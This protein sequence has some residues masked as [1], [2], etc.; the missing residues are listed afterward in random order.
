M[1]FSV[2]GAAGWLD[3]SVSAL[4]AAIK[5]GEVAAI[6]CT[7]RDDK[8]LIFITDEALYSALVEYQPLNLYWFQNYYQRYAPLT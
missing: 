1:L 4:R 8:E 6:V 3:V 5:R 2:E 7:G